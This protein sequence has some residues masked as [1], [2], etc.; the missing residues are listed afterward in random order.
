MTDKLQ[1]PTAQPSPPPPDRTSR[2]IRYRRILIICMHLVLFAVSLLLAFGLAYN[3][4]FSGE[5]WSHL[6]L[7][8][9]PAVLFIKLVVFWSFGLYHGWW[10]YVSLQDLIRITIAT[11][12]S[13]FL[14]ALLYFVAPSEYGLKRLSPGLVELVGFEHFRQTVFLLDWLCTI[15]LVSAR[16]IA[17]S[18]TSS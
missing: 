2:L 17:R 1:E 15:L 5:V 16:R 6:F 18:G 12:I 3:F 8:M 14:F 10:R 13:T 7:P 11:H 4:D 9:L